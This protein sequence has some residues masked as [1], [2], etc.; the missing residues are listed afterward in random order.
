MRTSRTIHELSELLSLVQTDLQ[1]RC[2]A[3]SMLPE[4]LPDWFCELG[5]LDICFQQRLP[6]STK[7]ML[8]KKGEERSARRNVS[9]LDPKRHK[10]PW[11]ES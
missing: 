4:S 2:N 1:S 6:R 8:I 7:C 9:K 10:R 3:T 5:T 11:P